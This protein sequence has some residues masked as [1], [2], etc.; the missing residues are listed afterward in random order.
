MI[1]IDDS[2]VSEW[3]TDK[4]NDLREYF[5]KLSHR[6]MPAQVGYT[7][8]RMC[9]NPKMTYLARTVPTGVLMEA[10]GAFDGCV[11]EAFKGIHELTS[12]EYYEV[13]QRVRLPIKLGGMRLPSLTSIAPA[14]YA[15]S[16]VHIL[17]TKPQR[18]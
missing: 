2:K 10:A 15:T 6:L 14:A 7:L 11:T 13:E 9:A 12:D 4:V 3:C 16:L 8:L 1:S 5:D 17:S 18:V